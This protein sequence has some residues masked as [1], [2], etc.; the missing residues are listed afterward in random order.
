MGLHSH[1]NHCVIT[2]EKEEIL[3]VSSEILSR[4]CATIDGVLE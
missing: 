4:V 1:F 2:T 3:L